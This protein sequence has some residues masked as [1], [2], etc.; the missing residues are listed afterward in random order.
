MKEIARRLI[1]FF[2][3]SVLLDAGAG[4]AWSFKEHESGQS[5]S[6][7]EG[8]GVA[9]FHMF[10][11][12]LFSGDSNNPHQADG[13]CRTLATQLARR[14]TTTLADGLSKITAQKVASAMQ[15]SD[16]N[17]LVGLDGRSS[18]LINLSKALKANTKFFGTR[19]RPG[20]LIGV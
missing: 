9:T 15:V 11:Q 7:S 12:G 3:V 20:H 19:A 14:L 8:L 2:L 16:S 5:F 4:N 18:L 6:R 13:Q 1:D 10:E 17:P